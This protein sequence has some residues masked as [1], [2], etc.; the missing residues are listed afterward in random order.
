M[1]KKS[2]LLKRVFILSNYVRIIFKIFFYLKLYSINEIH[3]SNILLQ[4]SPSIF[5]IHK[6]SKFQSI[7]LSISSQ[8]EFL[9][10]IYRMDNGKSWTTTC[11]HSFLW[12]E[13]RSRGNFTLYID[14]ILNELKTQLSR[15]WL[16]NQKTEGDKQQSH[17]P[18]FLLF[19]FLNCFSEVT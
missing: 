3:A 18:L 14:I 1:L 5:K 11:A 7:S 8:W 10:L 12:Q 17:Y 9:V 13:K 16:I 2:I 19:F 6:A 15:V 4:N